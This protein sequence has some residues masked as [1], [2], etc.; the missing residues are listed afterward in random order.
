MHAYILRY[1]TLE[2][3]KATDEK[4]VTCVM[5]SSLLAAHFW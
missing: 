5:F 1:M 3:A 4:N 2:A